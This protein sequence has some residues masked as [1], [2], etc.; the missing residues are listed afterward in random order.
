MGME[1]LEFRWWVELVGSFTGYYILPALPIGYAL[2]WLKR[3]ICGS[4]AGKAV[5]GILAVITTLG[6]LAWAYIAMLLIV[7]TTEE[8]HKLMPGLLFVNKA[9]LFWSGSGIVACCRELCYTKK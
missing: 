9:T 4:R 3:K 6:F 2:L 7:F 5:V 8:E 1:N